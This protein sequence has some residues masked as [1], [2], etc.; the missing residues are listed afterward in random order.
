MDNSML[1]YRVV[2]VYNPELRNYILESFT[3]YQHVEAPRH[4]TNLNNVIE[5][6]HQ[7]DQ[8]YPW[9]EMSML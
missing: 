2:W 5:L 6:I 9:V 1:S 7:T 3:G 8:Q 4:L